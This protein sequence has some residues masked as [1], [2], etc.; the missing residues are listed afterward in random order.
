MIREHDIT[1][2]CL[3]CRYAR[4]DEEDQ[5]SVVVGLIVGLGVACLIYTGLAVLLY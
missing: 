3:D 5:L 4:Q 2:D 1:C